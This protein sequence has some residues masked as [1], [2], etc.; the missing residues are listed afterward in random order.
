M[1][2]KKFHNNRVEIDKDPRLS[3]KLVTLWYKKGKGNVGSTRK[4]ENRKENR[5]SRDPNKGFDLASLTTVFRPTIL[6]D[7]NMKQI[8]NECLEQSYKRF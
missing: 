2:L 1:K 6:R 8:S 3:T 5:M 7:R 4:C